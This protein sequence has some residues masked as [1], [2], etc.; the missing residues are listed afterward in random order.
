MLGWSSAFNTRASCARSAMPKSPPRRRRLTATRVG[1]PPSAGVYSATSTG[2][3]GG[4]GV[5]VDPERGLL[6]E[7]GQPGGWRPP[8]A[9]AAAR[10]PRSLPPPP[11]PQP[12]PPPTCRKTARPDPPLHF[13]RGRRNERGVAHHALEDG[14]GEGGA[15]GEGRRGVGRRRRRWGRGFGPRGRLPQ[16]GVGRSR[17]AVS[18]IRRAGHG[19]TR[20]RRQVRRPASAPARHSRGLGQLAGG[21]GDTS[22]ASA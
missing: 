4:E 15:L 18:V 12:P 3:G 17:G 19:G 9:G 2:G 11:P 6:F 5:H 10:A 20:E 22:G 8:A 14:Q 21:R 1:G 7:A 16:V 13:E